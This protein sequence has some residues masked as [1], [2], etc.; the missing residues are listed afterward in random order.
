MLYLMHIS[1]IVLIGYGV[2]E[3][4]RF[5]SPYRFASCTGLVPSAYSSR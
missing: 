3:I 2:G 4:T 1:L 5:R